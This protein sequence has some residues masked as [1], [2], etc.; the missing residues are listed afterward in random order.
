MLFFIIILGAIG[1]IFTALLETKEWLS[2][3]QTIFKLFYTQILVSFMGPVLFSV[4]YSYKDSI[5]LPILLGLV[6]IFISFIHLG[7]ITLP[8]KF[9]YY[10]SIHLILIC[11]ISAL[12]GLD[13]HD[14]IAGPLIFLIFLPVLLLFTQ[15]ISKFNGKSRENV[16][17]LLELSGILNSIF[18]FVIGLVIAS[19][20]VKFLKKIAQLLFN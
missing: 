11:T 9:N 7:I 4:I 16:N 1:A 18:I 5:F 15:K 20:R 10:F 3:N 2:S 14:A 17:E 12:S 8:R 13:W 19:D 6:F